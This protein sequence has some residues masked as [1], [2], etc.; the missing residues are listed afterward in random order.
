[1]SI[2]TP[3]PSSAFSQKGTLA[4]IAF[5]ID[6]GLTHPFFDRMTDGS[7]EAADLRLRFEFG[8]DAARIRLPRPAT[9]SDRIELEHQ[10]THLRLDVLH[11]QFSEW[12]DTWQI[13]QR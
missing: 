10:G 1:M 13:S 9:S 5:A 12:T 2:S 7:F 3:P 11:A 8:G 6:Q 4:G